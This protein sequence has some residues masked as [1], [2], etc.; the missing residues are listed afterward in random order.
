VATGVVK[1]MHKGM[2]NTPNEG[3]LI[4]HGTGTEYSF[5]RPDLAFGE[6]PRKWNV[7]THDIVSFTISGNVAT[8]VVLYKKA[9]NGTIYG[10]FPIFGSHS[11]IEGHSVGHCTIIGEFG[12]KLRLIGSIGGGSVI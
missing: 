1:R 6:V 11:F 9:S 7:E 8:G 10:S 3:V 2:V 4:E 12:G 5:R